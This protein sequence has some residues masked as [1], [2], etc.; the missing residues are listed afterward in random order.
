M[1]L[2]YSSP[3]EIMEFIKEL[4]DNEKIIKKQITDMLLYIDNM[5]YVELLNMPTDMRELIARG[6]NAKMEKQKQNNR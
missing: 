3:D 1:K 2:L 4:R 5:T 6:H